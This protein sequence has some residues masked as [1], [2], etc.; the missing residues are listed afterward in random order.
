MHCVVIILHVSGRNIQHHMNRTYVASSR[1]TTLQ[2]FTSARPRLS[3]ERSPTLR[4]APSLSITVSNVYRFTLLVVSLMLDSVDWSL[5]ESDS[6]RQARRNASQSLASSCL[7]KGSRLDLIVPVRADSV[8][9][10]PI[11]THCQNAYH[12]RGEANSAMISR[13]DLI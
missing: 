7:L 13:V 3:N 10:L 11:W 5:L 4:F 2:S 1:M 6:M 8:S 12:W 9:R